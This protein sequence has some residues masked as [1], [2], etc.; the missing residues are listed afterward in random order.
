MDNHLEVSSGQD[1]KGHYA[2][3]RADMV[4]E[5]LERLEP[6]VAKAFMEKMIPEFKGHQ[7][8]FY[9]WLTLPA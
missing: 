3:P 6:E 7:V 9:P 8:S 4:C 1:A 5:S 2:G